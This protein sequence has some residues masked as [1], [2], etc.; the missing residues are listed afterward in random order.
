MTLTITPGDIAADSYASLVQA[1]AY[2][3]A[4][5][6]S[7]WT[8]TD[9]LKEAA[10]TRATQ[11][12]DGRYNSRWPG[13][14]WK[15]RLQALDWPRVDALDRDGTLIDADEIPVEVINATCEAALR[16]LTTPGI[17]SPDITPGTVKVLTKVEGIQ[18][19]P[20]RGG[21]G[22]QEMTLTITAVDRALAPI[23]GGGAGQARV[24]RA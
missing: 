14:R 15:L 13:T 16:E 20:L 12:L 22:V 19:T 3:T 8:G 10:L 23:I 7:T 17:L 4:R 2:H 9:A 24:L 1:A 6:N 11:W 5:G 21:A 18:W